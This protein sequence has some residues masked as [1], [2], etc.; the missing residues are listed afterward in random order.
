MVYETIIILGVVYETALFAKKH[1]IGN[2]S[3][4]DIARQLLP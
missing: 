3:K 4:N 1:T 2:V